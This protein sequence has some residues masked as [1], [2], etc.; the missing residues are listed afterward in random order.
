MGHP[1][2]QVSREPT[3]CS[4]TPPPGHCP[5]WQ[6]AGRGSERETETKTETDQLTITENEHLT[7]I[8][9]LYVHVDVCQ[10]LSA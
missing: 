10:P 4:L 8:T 2:C 5:A 9:Y 6:P 3:D 7:F 1:F